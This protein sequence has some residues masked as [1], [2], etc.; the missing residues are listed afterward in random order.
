M[1]VDQFS[2]ATCLLEGM[3]FLS[4]WGNEKSSGDSNFPS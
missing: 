1:T 4:M 2:G 3:S